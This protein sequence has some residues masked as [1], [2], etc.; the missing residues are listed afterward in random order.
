MAFYALSMA[1]I[2]ALLNRSGTRSSSDLVLKFLEHFAGIREAM[3]AQHIWDDTDGL[4]YDRLLTPTGAGV[5]V[6]VRSM[7]G[8]IPL[9]AVVVIDEPMLQRAKHVGKS[10]AAFLTRLGYGDLTEL[11]ASGLVRGEPPNRQLLL[12]VVER[13]QLRRVF[14]RLFDEA[15][16]L[17]PHG[18]RSISAYHREHPYVLDVE[19][20]HAAIDYE[21][22]ESTT[23]MFGGNS[24]WRGPVWFP[25]NYLLLSMIERYARFFADAD[26]IEYPTGSGALV[27]LERVVDDLWDRL[28]SIFLVGPDGRRPCFGGVERMQRDAAWKDNVLFFEYFHGDNAAG[29]G[30]SHQTGWTGIVADMIRRRHGATLNLGEMLRAL[31]PAVNG[32]QS[33]A[34][35][36]QTPVE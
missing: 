17:S 6:K 35:E 5:P 27:P 34:P 1:T 14:A 30:A 10:F 25:L 33:N 13:E 11:D 9:L 32:Q 23:S 3:D 28:I 36:A 22:A 20:L 7:V 29:L 15:E 19:D 31:A 16:F 2:V 18:L 12:G 24:N 4:A 21:P 8:L 26:T